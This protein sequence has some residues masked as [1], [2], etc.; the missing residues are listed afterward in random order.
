M[1]K[2]FELALKL[3]E[4]W[5]YDVD[6]TL[7]KPKEMIEKPLSIVDPS[8]EMIDPIPDIRELFVEFNAAYFDGKLAGVEVKWSPRMTLCAG[9]CCY[10][11]R[12]GYCSIKLSSPLLKL[13]P[14]KDLVETLLHE[15]IHALLF[16]TQNNKD[17]DG[18]G[19]EFHKHM[20][21]LNNLTGTNISVY[22]SFHDEVNNYRNHWWRCD[23]PC[24]KWSP[25]YGIVRRAMNRA[26][27]ARDTWWA[28]H[29]QKCGGTYT[30]IKEP[31]NYGKKKPKVESKKTESNANTNNKTKDI[32]PKADFFGKTNSGVS[33]KN[34]KTSENI[35]P[36][37]TI[38]SSNIKNG[39][40]LKN[41]SFW[42][43]KTVNSNI[44]GVGSFDGESNEEIYSASS[45]NAS[46]DIHGF[47]MSANKKIE[48]NINSF[49]G[50]GFQLTNPSE[51]NTHTKA[52]SVA[53]KND[54]ASRREA[55][56][57]RLETNNLISAPKKRKVEGQENIG[58][59]TCLVEM[60]NEANALK[61]VNKR[62]VGSVPS[63]TETISSTM[64]PKLDLTKQ[65]F[66]SEVTNK[67]PNIK[68]EVA[69][70]KHDIKSKVANK[71]H[72][73]KFE[74]ENKKHDIICLDDSLNESLIC[75]DI[76][77][78]KLVECPACP[79]KVPEHKLNEHL[80]SCLS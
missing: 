70:K 7:K 73:I 51:I 32:K 3:S 53:H 76:A 67:K 54:H 57:K 56:L 22:H 5:N 24:V 43:N 55:F 60:K 44:K 11:G 48:T 34:K 80:D 30:K 28:Q 52:V 14:R 16:V 74:V 1:D 19:P 9:V 69:N 10:Q 41:D 26:P 15:M 59:N 23:G 40:H 18:H 39:A 35:I 21:R 77:T 13:R 17:H 38:T 50:Q 12:S 64:V 79:C 6:T 45:K 36:S 72:D 37:S 27:S 71:K 58:V 62:V 2:D 42:K 68:F 46:S 78:V 25:Y 66:K 61:D 49:A 4:E 20:Y 75:G 63:I 29:K 33:N 8:W 65:V 31:E 47:K